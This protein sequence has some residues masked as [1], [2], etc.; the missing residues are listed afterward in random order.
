MLDTTRDMGTDSKKTTAHG[1]FGKDAAGFSLSYFDGDY[2]PI[3]GKKFEATATAAGFGLSSPALYN[4]NI[5][6]ATYALDKLTDKT[7]G[8]S[9]TYDQLNRLVGMNAW[10]NFDYPNFKWPAGI[11]SNKWEEDITYD[12]NG[13][14]LTYIRRGSSPVGMDSLTYNYY[15]NKNQ[16]GWVNDKTS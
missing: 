14:I 15:R 8:Y 9:Y 11:A 3:G 12:A 7:I 5:R 4:G 10:T 16:L 2:K 1:A 6:R 13:N